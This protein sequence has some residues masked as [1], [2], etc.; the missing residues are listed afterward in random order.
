MMSL[1]KMCQPILTT[2]LQHYFNPQLP[3]RKRRKSNVILTA[4][5]VFQ[6][7]ASSQKATISLDPIHSRI[8]DFNPQL[9]RRKRPATAAWNALCAIFQ[10]TASSQQATNAIALA[11][12]MSQISIHSFLAESDFIVAFVA[13]YGWISIH[14]FLA[15]SDC[16]WR[17]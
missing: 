1:R 2:S 9:P 10:S 12:N 5:G 11:S 13:M 14:S 8:C 17:F 15:E 3:R 6:S 7:T 4:G 16:A